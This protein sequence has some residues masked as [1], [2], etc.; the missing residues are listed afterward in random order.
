MTCYGEP[1]LRIHVPIRA[2]VTASFAVVMTAGLFAAPVLATPAQAASTHPSTVKPARPPL[3]AAQVRADQRRFDAAQRTRTSLTGLVRTAAGA[4]LA[5]ICVT[6][7]GPSG[8]TTAVTRS[9]GRFL[10][11]GLRPGKYQVQYRTCAGALSRYVPEWYGDVL[12]RGQS[13]SV[14]VNG[15][16]LTPVQALR[17]VT[18]YP[19]N[20]NLGDLP[21]AVVPQ[22]G[23]DV[24]ASDPFG[25]LATGPASPSVLMRSLA[26]RFLPAAS[27]SAKASK[28][29]GRISGVVTAPNGK[30]LPG[31]CVEV[32]SS[33]AGL[34]VRTGKNG[35]YSTP[36][37]PSGT[38][39]MAFYALCGNNG[40]WLFEIYKNIF[41][42]LKTPTPIR[43]KAGKTTHIS[44]VM[45]DGGEIS[46][47]VTGPGG[48]KLSN[49]CVSPLTNSPAGQLVFTAVSKH[50]VYHIRSVPPGRYQIGFAPCEQSTWAPTLWPD[51]QN[52]NAAPYIRVSGTHH[53]GNIDEV[54][55][56]GGIITGTVTAATPAATPLAGMCVLAQ[57]NGG[58]FDTGSVATNAD[59][60]YE[61]YGLA[62]GSY[63]V[64]FYPGCNSNANYVGINY[65][66]NVNVVGG[67]TT[68]G[69]NG[70]LPVGAIIAGTATSATTGK[71]IEGICVSLSTSQLGSIGLAITNA[72]GAYSIDQLPVGTYQVQFSGGCG[73][74]GS[75]APQGWNNTNVLEPQNIDLTAAGQDD[76]DISAALQPG[77]VIAGTV[78]DSSGRRLSGI[79]VYAATPSG[80]LFGAGQTDHGRYKM[81][82]LAPGS[83]EVIFT[84]GCGNNADLAEEVFKTPLSALT[85][86]TVSASSGT[87]SGINAVMQGAGGISGDVRAK[88]RHPVALT[89][90]ILTGVS[91]SARGLSGEVLT[92]GGSYEVTGLPVGGYQV[93]FDPACFGID[94]AAQWYKDKPSPAGATTVV[95]RASHVDPHIN[96]SLVVG[97]TI[98]GTITTTGG[99]RVHN[100]C[101][102]AQNVTQ[103]LDFGGAITKPNGTYYIHGLNSGVYE[104]LVSPCGPG[105][106][107]LAAEVLPQEVQVTAPHRANAGTA[108]VP[109]GGSIKGTVL[110]GS[111]ATGNGAAGACVEALATNGTAYN[112][113]NA[114]LDGT[115]RIPNLPG[116]DYLVYVGDPS[117]SFSE[118]SLAPQWYLGKSTPS[119]ATAVSV[120][121]GATTTISDTTLAQ[122]GSISGTVTGTGHSPLGGV[123]VAATSTIAGSAPVY[124]VTSGASGGYSIG[125]L[126]AGQ[127]RVQ[128][129]SGC[130]AAGYHSQ[131]W[132]DKPS[133][134]TA[135]IVTVTAG[136]ATTGIGAVLS[137]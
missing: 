97:G 93:T 104:L 53:V 89:C 10:L 83:Y 137:K 12:Q 8:T 17:S 15:S 49:I 110:A 70:A 121:S 108:S 107:Y 95:I 79:C 130:G 71:P 101:V 127:Y 45:K 52:E 128:F 18:L 73:N 36:R 54:M 118:P 56:P 115:F 22:H 57:E 47:T 60:D 5:D 124:S 122:D 61:V 72:S 86:A 2:V 98:V 63:S 125:D 68:P 65:P 4:P 46:G 14:I 129:S 119:G 94:L 103:P 19:A 76:A 48:R 58:L 31:I 55:Q 50:G 96:S 32:V 6:A 69:I 42:P 116:G 85:P 123:C 77:P 28:K 105:S 117:C 111:P 131:W 38:Y 114:G 23:S 35:S 100:M 64:Q 120:S 62:P 81:L 34:L 21:T 112:G 13:R 33:N 74:T 133:E 11:N 24:V 39:L 30:G 80:V 7:Y 102:D 3:S 29:T 27:E 44:A 132:K 99:K 75:Y 25:R 106:N 92:L 126:P 51:T 41:N 90:I 91:G 16:T 37:L 135:S 88:S 109:S 59:G 82:N 20:S 84:P 66:T 26:K 1:S 43:V 67:T 87:V 9:N 113:T 136:T 78:T 134:Q 40:N